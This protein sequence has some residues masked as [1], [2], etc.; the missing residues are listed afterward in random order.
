MAFSPEKAEALLD[1]AIDHDR[2]A[3]AY[4]ICGER[5]SGKLRVALHM[6]EKLM[7]RRADSLEALRSEH[8]QVIRPESKSRR[9][10]VESIRA[11]ERRLN[12]AV[13]AGVTK[14]AII[15]E[16]DRMM[17]EAANAF[18]KTLEEPPDRSLIL[19]LTAAPEQL[20]PTTLSRCLKVALKGPRPAP[21]SEVEDELLADLAGLFGP[22]KANAAGR[23][24][25]WSVMQ[26]FTALLKKEKERIAKHH[27]SLMRA[28]RE[29]YG[30]V[31]EG[32]WLKRREEALSALTEAQYLEVRMRLL[33][34]MMNWLGDALR[35]QSGGGTLELP[36]HAVATQAVG[37]A[38]SRE[39]LL[40]RYAALDALRGHLQTNVNEGLALESGFLKA[41]G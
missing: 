8:V 20:L 18:L 5:G 10:R 9:I 21:T 34:T 6:V 39:A 1:E 24:R 4:L 40:R 12:L 3:H 36:D 32:D 33:Q 22:G 19:L 15:A 23:S 30:K 35:Q 11:M 13:P 17:T 14:V 31:T 38:E 27:E 37:A 29:A 16:A 28:D 41:F 7:G 25:A 26:R 2:L